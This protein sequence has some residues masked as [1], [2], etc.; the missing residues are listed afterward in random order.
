MNGRNAL[1]GLVRG[2]PAPKIQSE[3]HRDSK[4]ERCETQPMRMTDGAGL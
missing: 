3:Q 4:L 2:Q 1:L